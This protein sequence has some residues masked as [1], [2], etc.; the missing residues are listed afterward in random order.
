MVTFTEISAILAY[1]GG[2]GDGARKLTEGVAQMTW[3]TMEQ[4]LK[5]AAALK[6]IGDVTEK[7]A[8]AAIAAGQFVNAAAEG[9][10]TF[11]AAYESV[12]GV[13][14]VAEACEGAAL[15]G[16]ASGQLGAAAAEGAVEGAALAGGA[17][18]Q[19]GAAAAE[20]AVEG[21]AIAG[22]GVRAS[23]GAA[24]KATAAVSK[25]AIAGGVAAGAGIILGGVDIGVS[26][27]QLVNGTPNQNHV[28]DTRKLVEKALS[29]YGHT[30]REQQKALRR[31]LR[32]LE[33]LEADVKV[34]VEAVAGTKIG[35]GTAGVAGGA[36]SIA[37]LFFPPLLLPGLITG[38][39]GAVAGAT[40]SII[41]LCE[42]HTKR[43]KNI[44]AGLFEYGL[45]LELMSNNNNEEKSMKM[46]K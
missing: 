12:K 29:N 17:S 24:G 18:V 21:A 42:G 36:L 16:R 32:D 3:M 11:R 44:M 37:G 35:G 45:V 28:I 40:A 34:H 15:A 14:A 38:I 2:V 20:G 22:Q 10:S 43:L 1:I 6:S 4:N 23:L 33:T 27:Y 41:D 13:G 39:V 26:I 9:A 46:I 31:A 30:S 25:T 19:L 8:E 7:G 5:L